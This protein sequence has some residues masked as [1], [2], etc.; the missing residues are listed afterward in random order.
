[1][2]GY[3][4][5]SQLVADRRGWPIT[6][7]E[8][9]A[10]MER[11]ASHT[12][13]PRVL[14]ELFGA[15][16]NDSFVIAECLA[17]PLVAE[18]LSTELGGQRS[19]K[20]FA[21]A[22]VTTL[23]AATAL[24]SQSYKLPHI[25]VSLDCIDDTWTPTT[26]VNAPDARF[27]HTAIWTGSEMIIWGGAFLDNG[28]HY[29]N[30]GGRYDPATDT[31]LVTSITNAPTARWLHNAVWTG[32]EMI[33]WGGYSDATGEVST[34]GQYDPITDSWT[35]TTTAN[36][37]TARVHHTA[38]W[39]GSEMVVWGGYGCNGNCNFNSGVRYNPQKDS[40]TPTSTTN[41]PERRW[42]HSVEWTGSE[43]IVWGGTNDTIYL[44]TGAKYNPA[45]DSWT[46][47]STAKAPLGRVGHTWIWSGSEMMVW[48][49]TDS[50]FNDC[51]TGGRYNPTMDSWSATSTDNA[52]SPR[53]S[54]AAVWTGS[55]M[56]VWGGHNFEDNMFFNTGGRY[57]AQ[58]G[59]TPTPTLTATATPT[60]TPSAYPHGYSNA[61]HDTSSDTNTQN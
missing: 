13:H 20:A 8:L 57:C 9:Q 53:D 5:K 40:W 18:R 31:W 26:T 7:S 1:V 43:M 27:G 24:A 44:N 12:L 14:L 3:L 60:A 39:S 36:T 17:R 35:T 41:A 2:G 56:I 4:G 61:G 42:D 52:P 38:I 48:G 50:T 33:I 15:L 47:T 45:D 49:G 55:E 51:N 46:P 6:A 59:S 34:G 19:V 29:L 32:S 22:N 28:Y 25:S 30:T 23:T 10:E 58:S 21:A 54:L 16:D 11:M 37:P